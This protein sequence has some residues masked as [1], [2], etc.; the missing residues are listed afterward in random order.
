M[1]YN[2]QYVCS[3]QDSDVFIETDII[4]AEEKEFVRNCIY[5]QDLLNIFSMEEFDDSLINEKLTELYTQIKYYSVLDDCMREMA[6]SISA[7]DSMFGLMMLFS[8]DYLYLFHPFIC[9][10][11]EN[12]SIENIDE[13][14]RKIS[15]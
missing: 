8:F 14:K 12:G 2:T 15:V 13:L 7:T 4:T 9:E 6:K 10:Y 1:L 11:L 3:Y 5:R